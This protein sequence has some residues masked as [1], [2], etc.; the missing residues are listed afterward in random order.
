MG[1]SGV[2]SVSAG[3]FLDDFFAFSF[4]FFCPALRVY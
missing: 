4:S 3:F 2:P 1:S